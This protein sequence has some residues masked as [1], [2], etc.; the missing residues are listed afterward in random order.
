MSAAWWALRGAECVVGVAADALGWPFL[1]P[2]RLG[3]VRRSTPAGAWVHA[4]SLGEAA[5]VPP[6]A[7][8]LRREAGEVR[9]LCTATTAAGLRRLR[10]R[11]PAPDAAMAPLD[12][13]WLVERFLS[14]VAPRLALLVETE[15]WPHWLLA[16][17]RRRTP[18]AVVS[19]RLSP[20]SLRA[21]RWLGAPF[22]RALG[23]LAAVLAQSEEDASRWREAG[24]PADRVEVGGSLKVDA[25]PVGRADRAAARQRLGLEP[26]RPV[27]T[28]GSVRPGEA[29]RLARAWAAQPVALR[30]A[31]QVVLVPRHLKAAAALAR[32]VEEL[33]IPLVLHERGLAPSLMAAAEA[34]PSPRPWRLHAELGVLGAYY[35][36]ADVAF[37]GGSLE[38]HGGHNPLEPAA[39]GVPVVMGPHHASQLTAVR[40]LCARGGLVVAEDAPALEAALAGLLGDGAA[41]QR[42]GAAAL[43]SVRLMQG[44]AARTVAALAA[45]G[46]WP[47]R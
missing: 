28:L 25:L 19:A 7:D 5:A 13:P 39:L 29:R 12:A 20:G 31:W 6:L 9:L 37:V 24:V 11:C 44:V 1:A 8:A 36:A 43:E 35:E 33:G 15:L 38:P 46:L 47:P 45:R 34:G 10:Q 42:R 27:L 30:E 2:G 40:A 17:E 14:R 18:V 32:E 22:R 41:R 16:L 23:T 21:Y 3:R 4:A 26:L